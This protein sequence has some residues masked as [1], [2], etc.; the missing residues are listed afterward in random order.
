MDSA[1]QAALSS[2]T[3][4]E[5]QAQSQIHNPAGSGNGFYD[6]RHLNEYASDGRLADG[7]RE[8]LLRPMRRFESLP[9]NLT[10]SS[11]LVPPGIDVNGELCQKFHLAHRY[12]T[13]WIVIYDLLKCIIY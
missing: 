9:V 4:Q 10:L 1:E 6:S 13:N 8:M 7:A 2:E 12:S 3:D 5:P 11:I